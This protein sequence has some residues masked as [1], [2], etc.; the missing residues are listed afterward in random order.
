MIIYCY[1]TQGI[2]VYHIYLS[3]LIYN[4]IKIPP[5]NILTF[6]GNRLQDL[7]LCI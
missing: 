1:G 2:N 5:L 3:I 4:A 6:I 7:I